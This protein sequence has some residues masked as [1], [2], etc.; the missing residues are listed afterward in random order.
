MTDGLLSQIYLV[1]RLALINH[2]FVSGFSATVDLSCTLVLTV[3]LHLSEIDPI[4]PFYV[5]GGQWT[6]SCSCHI[7]YILHCTQIERFLRC[8]LVFVTIFDPFVFNWPPVPI[9]I[10]C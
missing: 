6:C 5:R 1:P 3:G 9:K 7:N 10:K 4:C 8:N 2:L